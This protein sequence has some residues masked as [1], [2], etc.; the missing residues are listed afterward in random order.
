LIMN[1]S[2]AS[3]PH[4]SNIHNNTRRMMMDVIIALLPAIGV[5]IWMFR[6]YAV[7]QIGC[8]V[9]VSSLT[10]IGWKKLSGKPISVTDLSA[11]LTG[12]ILAL[13]LPWSAPIYVP[14]IGSFV[15]I[16]LGKMVFGGLGMN[17]FNPAMVGRAFVMLSFAGALGASAYVYP[18]AIIPALT[19]ATPLTI[20][21]T[22]A[23]GMNLPDLWMLFIGNTNGSLGETSSLAILLGGIYLLVRRTVAWQ[24]PA[25][26]IIGAGLPAL[27]IHLLGLSELTVLQHLVS[28]SLLFGA[29]FIA[30]DPVSSP[31]T[32][33]GRLIFGGGVGLLVVVLRVFS[34]YPEGVMFAVLLMNAVVPLI[35]RGTIPT[36]VGGTV[37]VKK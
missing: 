20:A 12:L 36:P 11:P 37:P 21:K 8:C 23:S 24:I 13:S 2:V 31:I 14:V 19:Q 7:L 30:T 34:S 10:E 26:V 3:S 35:N 15:A 33:K 5:S 29:F 6:W 17:L 22:T 27:L 18:D 16:A 25:G 4:F 9:L 28:G 1:V 32:P